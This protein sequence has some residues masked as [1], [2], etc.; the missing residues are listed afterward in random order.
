MNW[1]NMLSGLTLAANCLLC[2]FLLFYDRLVVPSFLQVMGRAHPLFLHFP[3]V[4]FALFIIWI[5]VIPKQR[6]H[7]V[8]LS[9][10]VG[11]WLLLSVAFTSAITALMG[12][13][14]SREPG[15]NEESLWLHK[16][17]GACLSFIVFVWYLFH[18]RLNR[19]RPSLAAVSLT[20]LLLLVIAGH[21][22]ATITHGDNFLL[23]PVYKDRAKEKVPFD[24]AIVFRDMVQPVLDA[25]C[26]GCHNSGKA[27]GGLVMTTPELLLKGGRNGPVLDTS[28]ANMSLLLQRIHLP[29]EDRKHMPPRGRPQLNDQ[30]M[31]VLYNWI[32]RG[33]SFTV[34]VDSLEPTDTL[35]TIASN[36]FRTSGDQETYDF[37]A[38]GEEKVRQLNTDYRAVYPLATGS[39]AVAADFFGASFYK[40]GQLKDLLAIKTQLVSLNLT[41]MPVTDDELSVIG[42]FANLRELDLSFTRITG[43]TL[44]ALEKL[45]HLKRI[46]LTNTTVRREDI[47]KLLVLKELRQIYVWNAG[48]SFADAN[49]LKRKYPMLDIQTG[50]RTD[51]MSLKINP[52]LNQTSAQ[53]IS[54]TP[55]QLRLKHFVPGTTIRYTL[56]G[57]DPDSLHSMV[58]DGRTFIDS[59]VLMKARAFRKG[60]RPSE[61]VQAQFYRATFKPDTIILMTPADS[62][63]MGKGGTTLKDLQK[64][65]QNFGDGK[66]IAFRRNRMECMLQFS[67]PVRTRSI[68]VSSLVNVGAMIFPPK[69]IRIMGGNDPSNLRLLYQLAP[70]ADTLLTSNYLIPY[71]CKFPPVSAKYIRVIVEPVGKLPVSMLPSQPAPPKKDE[72]APSLAQKKEKPKPAND[73]G[74]FFVDELF[75]N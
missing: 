52:P 31:A 10:E 14:L 18:R 23:A 22:G 37:A 64:G 2:F 17:S 13:L 35:R 39:P 74:W 30:E 34:K 29:E 43:R 41:R 24:E 63:Y 7:A 3:I 69:N 12:V 49:E 45:H 48:L 20:S 54:D 62:S 11:E 73:K 44:S 27:K 19:S 16:W 70:P 33:A 72:K 50:A 46:S 58:Y 61:V 6:L 9:D 26:L 51:T 55:I 53:V 15:Y 1:K 66:W 28:D 47:A 38:A 60:W 65:S 67:K 40:P 32:R 59:Q 36:I 5:W 71:E 57:T 42:Q 75:V 4:L 8:G 25:K 68:T 21:Q 56:D